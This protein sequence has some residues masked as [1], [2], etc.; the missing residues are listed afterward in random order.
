[1]AGK[2]GTTS[3]NKDG[4]F[5]GFSSGIT[6]AVWMGRDDA[7][8]VRGLSGGTAP[9][10]AFASYMR[11]AVKGRPI[12]QFDTELKLPD[13]QLEPDD[14]Y[15]YGDPDEYYFIDEDGNLIEPNRQRGGVGPDFLEDDD[16]FGDDRPVAPSRTPEAAPPAANRDFLEEATG[17]PVN[18]PL[19]EEPINRR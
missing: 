14:E 17:G 18:S 7:K 13:W 11:V 9:A 15:F 8:A 19:V 5:V 3:S 1:V 16:P 10:R 6:T 12:E 4:W 2:T